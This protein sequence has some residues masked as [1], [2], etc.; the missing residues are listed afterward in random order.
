MIPVV[1]ESAPILTPMEWRVKETTRDLNTRNGS[2]FGDAACILVAALHTQPDENVF[3]W[4]GCV[5]RQRGV[6]GVRCAVCE[7]F[8]VRLCGSSLPSNHPIDLEFGNQQQQILSETSTSML[9]AFQLVRVQILYCYIVQRELE[10]L[11]TVLSGLWTLDS[12]LYSGLS[13]MYDREKEYL[14]CSHGTTLIG[15]PNTLA[16][17]VTLHASRFTSDTTRT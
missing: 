6:G 13:S 16:L 12:P 1:E 2:C 7:G 3:Y 14:Y 9:S 17:Q 10:V 4:K 11:G 15:V 5:W 8:V